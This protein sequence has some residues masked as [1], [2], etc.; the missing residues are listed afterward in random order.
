MNRREFMNRLDSCLICIEHGEREA[1]LRYYEEYFDDTGADKEAD[2][3]SSLGSPEALARE[4]IAQAGESAKGA[5]RASAP[6]G[7]NP[8]EFHSI[9]ADIVNANI[10]VKRGYEWRVDINYPDER[11]KPEVSLSNGVLRIS[12]EHHKLGNIFRIGGW[13]PGRID[14]TVPDVMF[15]SFEIEGVNGAIIVQDVSIDSIQCETVNGS[16]ELSGIRADVIRGESVNGGVSIT[17]CQA[18]T[19]CKGETVNGGV[20]LGGEL[21]GDISAETVNGTLRISSS[22]PITEYNLDVENI[23]GSVRINGE[24][25]RKEV[26]I[27]HGAQNR[28]R[29]EAVN[30]SISLE[31]AV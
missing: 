24:K 3:I 18:K 21:R 10:A 15:R 2:V 8:A 16:V 27:L 4:I 28:I 1:A 30:G 5:D 19:R 14:I 11:I 31:F 25:H 13:K 29:V 7:R 22:L 9:K 20:T 23:S 26:H 12:E 6:F 17:S